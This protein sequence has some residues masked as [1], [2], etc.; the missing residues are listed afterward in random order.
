ME[1]IENRMA[2]DSEWRDSQ[3]ENKMLP[4]CECCEER[5]RQRKALNILSGRRRVWICDRCIE[6]LKEYTGYED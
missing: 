6:D 2:V 3:P 1:Q 4:V 5:I